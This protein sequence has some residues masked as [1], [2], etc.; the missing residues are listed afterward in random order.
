ML[1]TSA[2]TS[3]RRQGKTGGISKQRDRYLRS[4]FTA[5]A[6]A[7]IGYSKILGTRHPP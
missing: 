7:V 3:E 1:A 5:G 6:L 2:V 4:L